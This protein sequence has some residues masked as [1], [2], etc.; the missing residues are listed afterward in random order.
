MYGVPLDLD[1]SFLH[2]AELIQICLG[3]YQLQFHFHP[4]GLISVE[5]EWE[6]VNSDGLRI[7]GWHD[8]PDRP[9]Y[10]LRALLGQRVADSVLSAP[11]WFALRFEG[12]DTLRVFDDSTQYESFQ[13]HP[14]NIIV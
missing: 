7:D 6:L 10:Q 12:G 2:G 11:E 5:G 1:L 14:G 13:I 9:P 3:L 4:T 8:G